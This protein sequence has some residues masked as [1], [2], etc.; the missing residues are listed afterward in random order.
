MAETGVP[1]YFCRNNAAYGLAAKMIV[2]P[3]GACFAR[4]S[5]VLFMTIYGDVCCI[6]FHLAPRRRKLRLR[7]AMTGREGYLR[8]GSLNDQDA[9][10][11]VRVDRGLLLIHVALT[12]LERFPHSP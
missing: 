9:R 6:C 11:V 7:Q 5:A 10:M 3:L 1:A 2:L 4:F 8:D 12:L